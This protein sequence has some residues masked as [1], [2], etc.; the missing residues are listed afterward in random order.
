MFLT[1]HGFAGCVTVPVLLFLVAPSLGAHGNQ[2]EVVKDPSITRAQALK[3]PAGK[4]GLRKLLI[5]RYNE[6]LAE[7]LFTYSQYKNSKVSVDALAPVGARLLKAGLELHDSVKDRIPFLEEVLDLA[8]WAEKL[9]ERRVRSIPDLAGELH[10]ARQFRLDVEIELLK[11]KK[12]AGQP[13]K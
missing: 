11:A 12:A 7:V 5:Q 2:K 3:I 4:N 1:S 9:S 6:A 8:N 10:R 13:G